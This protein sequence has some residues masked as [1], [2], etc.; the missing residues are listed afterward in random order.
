[1]M[2]DA[3]AYLKRLK[4]LRKQIEKREDEK[5]IEKIYAYVFELLKEVT[6]EKSQEKV[7]TICARYIH[8]GSSD[9]NQ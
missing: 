8:P 1:M 9:N 6:G 4:E 3:A 5:T 2:K 7:V